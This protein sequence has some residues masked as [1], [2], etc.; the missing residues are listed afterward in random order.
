M[1]KAF[2]IGGT[3][4]LKDVS[5]WLAKQ[6]YETTVLGRS[7]ER[8]E[9]LTKQEHKILPLVADYNDLKDF[10]QELKNHIEHHGKFDLIIAWI[11]YSEK[12][13]LDI[14]EN[15][16][17]GRTYDLY[18]I[19]SSI[20]NA[21]KV[22]QEIAPTNTV[23]YYQVQLGYKKENGKSRWLTNSEIAQGAIQSIETKK[24]VLIGQIEAIEDAP[25][26]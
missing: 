2:V 4:M 5:L 16:N 25:A 13:V 12:K 3:G 20:Q 6:G 18:H 21:N 24:S 26:Y 10:Q 23:S 15:E 8:I 9:I 17:A 14:V 19:I 7:P 11:H 22:R 1:K